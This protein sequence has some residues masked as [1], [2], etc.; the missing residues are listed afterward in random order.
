MYFDHIVPCSYPFLL[1]L[2]PLFYQQ[3]L[4][5]FFP[6]PMYIELWLPMQAWVGGMCWI[7]CH[8]PD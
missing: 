7:K 8:L 5:L 2:K 1:L 6:C 3:V 4:L